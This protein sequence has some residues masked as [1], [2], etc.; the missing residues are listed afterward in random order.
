MSTCPC[1][2]SLIPLH[3]CSS[4][5]QESYSLLQERVPLGLRSYL[6]RHD[7][8]FSQAVTVTVT[9]FVFRLLQSFAFPS[10]LNQLQHVSMATLSWYVMMCGLQVGF[11]L[12]WESL[13]STHGDEQGMLEDFIVAVGDIN[14]LTFKVPII[15]TPMYNFIHVHYYMCCVYTHNTH[16]C[17]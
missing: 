16:S 7:I 17:P 11:L 10:F 14:Q 8:V 1:S 13:L 9:S 3:S 6:H 12:H 4:F 15:I 2:L 5:V